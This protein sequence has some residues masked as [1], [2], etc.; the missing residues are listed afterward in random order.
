MQ[1][2]NIWRMPFGYAPTF[3]IIAGFILV[4]FALEFA[5]GGTGFPKPIAPINFFLIGFYLTI[6][7]ALYFVKPLKDLFRWFSSITMAVSSVIAYVVLIAVAGFVP[8][9][10]SGD[11]L[12]HR[13]GFTHMISSWPYVISFIFVTTSL[14]STIIKKSIK[15]KVRN[16]GFL[17]S[18]IGFFIILFFGTMSSGHLETYN[19]ELFI[20]SPE[21]QGFYF[22]KLRAGETPQLPDQDFIRRKVDLPFSLRMN[23]F[24]I[25]NYPSEILFYDSDG[26]P[27]KTKIKKEAG[28]VSEGKKFHFQDWEI[29]VDKY[30]ESATPR[31]EDYIPYDMDCDHPAFLSAAYLK[32]KNIQT[33]EEQEGWVTCGN[34]REHTPELSRMLMRLKYFFPPTYLDIGD[35]SVSIGQPGKK[36]FASYITMTNLEGKKTEKIVEVN[37]PFKYKNW[38]LYQTDCRYRLLHAEST[39]PL[40]V[41]TLQA[42]SDPWLKFVYIGFFLLLAGSIHMIW[43]I[44]KFPK[45]VK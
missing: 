31:K 22:D 45:E 4:G 42:V 14:Y 10:M 11:Q 21:H 19:V 8:Q 17:L 7:T 5:V 37:K 23:R 25:D 27:V 44:R 9:G 38:Y 2:S 30:L 36:R 28:F 40:R 26:F 34:T 29:T 33:N 41:S 3:I 35:I 12:L 20:D 32:A 13:I 24:E 43:S 39:D 1:K 6:L 15:F 18:H 16:V